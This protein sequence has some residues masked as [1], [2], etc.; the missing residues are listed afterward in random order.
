MDIVFSRHACTQAE[1]QK[2]LRFLFDCSHVS[3]IFLRSFFSAA[4]PS[5]YL[6]IGVDEGFV[7][8]LDGILTV[9]DRLQRSSQVVHVVETTT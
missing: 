6:R 7:G 8:S 1:K 2:P 9:N 5:Y 4:S 3:P